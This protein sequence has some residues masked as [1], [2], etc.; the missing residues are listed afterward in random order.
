MKPVSIAYK[1]SD[2]YQKWTKYCNKVAQCNKAILERYKAKGGNIMDLQ[3]AYYRGGEK[4]SMNHIRAVIGEL[5]ADMLF[6]QRA[7]V[8]KPSLPS[9]QKTNTS[10]RKRT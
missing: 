5:E 9:T 10:W 7:S 3:G 2:Y 8:I 6:N 1:Q 4:E